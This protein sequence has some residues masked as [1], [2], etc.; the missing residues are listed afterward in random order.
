MPLLQVGLMHFIRNSD[1][2]GFRFFFV[3]NRWLAVEEEDGAV[4][5]VIPVAT[6]SDMTQFS[7]LF[8]SSSRRSLF[9]DHIWFSLFSRPTRSN[10]TRVQRLSCCLCLLYLSMIA[11][12]MFYQGTDEGT[13]ENKTIL[14]IGSFIFTLQEVYVGF[15]SALVVVPV[16]IVI[17]QIFRKSKLSRCRSSVVPQHPQDNL[18]SALADHS[19]P[20]SSVGDLR[21]DKVELIPVN[22]TKGKDK[23]NRKARSKPFMLPHWCVYIAWLLMILSSVAAAFFTVLY[24]LEWGPER[25]S[26]WLTSMLMSLFNSVIIIQPFKA[27]HMVSI[28]FVP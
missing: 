21:S 19:T 13:T 8:Y 5:R 4:E 3:C 1:L 2:L 23:R 18:M 10:F 22:T 12:A 9:D 24:S 20:Q 17:V 14:R 11:N 6:R 7:K 16:N 25:S 15:I 26:E 27:S 28:H